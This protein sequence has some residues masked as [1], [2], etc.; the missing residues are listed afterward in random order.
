MIMT[1]Q[2]YIMLLQ[3]SYHVMSFQTPINFFLLWNTHSLVYT[4]RLCSAV[5]SSS[6]TRQQFSRRQAG[7]VK[8]AWGFYV[9][10]KVVRGGREYSDE[11]RQ[12]GGG[13]GVWRFGGMF[14]VFERRRQRNVLDCR[15]ESIL[16]ACM[17]VHLCLWVTAEGWKNRRLM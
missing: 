16:K 11:F 14:F 2:C 8:R 7:V 9:K 6:D 5:M 1:F 4:H 15:G 10:L 3:F 17:W 13:G 12:R